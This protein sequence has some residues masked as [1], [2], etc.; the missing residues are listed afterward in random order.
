MSYIGY[1]YKI[2][3]DETITDHYNY[4]LNCF[5]KVKEDR[6]NAIQIYY[7]DKRKTTLRYKYKLTP[8]E[9][10]NLKRYL[11]E[12]NLLLVI[13]SILT[14]NFCNPPDSMKFRWG[15]DNLIFDL[16]QCI[17]MGGFG[18]VLHLG[19]IKT[20][21]INISLEEGITNYVQSLIYVI[22]EIKKGTNKLFKIIIE[23][24]NRQK[25]TIGGTIEEIAELYHAIQQIKIFL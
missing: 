3:F 20:T 5:K 9:I 1:N 25:N 17:K 16:L 7:G 23:T 15:L 8:D 19:R 11:N 24:N 22:D 18:V 14:L 13:H 10:L 4:L 12:N 2:K 6:W 21:K